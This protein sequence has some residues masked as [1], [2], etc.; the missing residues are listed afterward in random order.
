MQNVHSKRN[1][2]ADGEVWE[3]MKK[4]RCLRPTTDRRKI[5]SSFRYLLN[6]GFSAF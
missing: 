4:S 6:D 2:Q 3:G 1:L 5:L